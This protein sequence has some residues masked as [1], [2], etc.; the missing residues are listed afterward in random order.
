MSDEPPIII[1]KREQGPLPHTNLVTFDVPGFKQGAIVVAKALA[2][3]SGERELIRMT[4]A[5]H[6]NDASILEETGI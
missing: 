2:D 5:N 3:T 4:L 1:L 6:A